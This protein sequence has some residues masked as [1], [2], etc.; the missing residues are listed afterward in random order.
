MGA[1]EIINRTQKPQN[2]PCRSRTTAMMSPFP[3]GCKRHVPTFQS[4]VFS[5]RRPVDMGADAP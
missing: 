2:P 3:L 1:G 4:P 5:F